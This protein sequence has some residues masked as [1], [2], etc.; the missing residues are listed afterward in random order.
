MKM[1]TELRGEVT[2]L[3]DERVDAKLDRKFN[4]FAIMVQNG[5]SEVLSKIETITNTMATKEDLEKLDKKLSSRMD[6]LESKVEGHDRR[7]D[8]LDDNIRLIK[9]KIGI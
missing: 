1:D 4:S 7:F 2:E 5:F 8:Y 9:T 3:V 6:R